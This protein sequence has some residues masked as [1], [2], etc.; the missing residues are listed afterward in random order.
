MTDPNLVN[1]GASP[2]AR[3]RRGG[4]ANNGTETSTLYDAAGTR[5]PPPPTGP[6]V[7]KVPGAPTGT[8]FYGG[9]RFP[10]S[11]GT[12]SVPAKFM[13][14]TEAGTIQGWPPGHRARP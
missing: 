4:S 14:A 12:G 1:A 8:V 3:R 6:L 10:V 2:K 5:F 9:T 7:V 13:F 11:N